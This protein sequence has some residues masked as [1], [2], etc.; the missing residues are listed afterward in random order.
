MGLSDYRHPIFGVQSFLKQMLPEIERGRIV[1]E[2]S[3]EHED[4]RIRHDVFV[5]FK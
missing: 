4:Q 1:I 2:I 5:D 3:T